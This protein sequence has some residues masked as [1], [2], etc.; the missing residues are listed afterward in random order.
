MDFKKILS[1][2]KGDVAG[3]DFHGNQHVKVDGAGNVKPRR[4]NRWIDSKGAFDPN[5]AIGKPVEPRVRA[6]IER[7]QGDINARIAQSQTKPIEPPVASKPMGDEKFVALKTPEVAKLINGEVAYGGMMNG[8]FKTVQMKDGSTGLI[9]T[10]VDGHPM[11]WDVSAEYQA[12][13]EVLA[14]KV[15]QAINAPVR[16]SEPLAGSAVDIVQP[17]LNGH[18]LG[19]MEPETDEESQMSGLRFFDQLVGNADRFDP[20][21]DIINGGN[22]FL[23]TG[24]QIIGIDNALCLLPKDFAVEPMRQQAM[25]DFNLL[26]SPTK[27]DLD[28]MFQNLKKT[29]PDFI[30]M[31]RQDN[32]ASMIDRFTTG[33]V[34]YL[35]NHPNLK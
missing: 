30:A 1:V 12:Q 3:H 21:G 24:N 7:A 26:G 23:T 20:Y 31:S 16:V 29:E 8:G 9:K 15:A 10:M 18:P 4:N 17:Y 25:P 22:I 28:T 19:D 35:V 34:T 32:Y 33:A 6:E 11:G 27:S 5:G 13:S 14:G 2:L